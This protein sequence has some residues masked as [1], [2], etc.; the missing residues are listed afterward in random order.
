MIISNVTIQNM[1]YI[2]LYS[3]ESH[4]EKEKT[5]VIESYECFPYNRRIQNAPKLFGATF[6]GNAIKVKRTQQFDRKQLLQPKSQCLNVFNSI[7]N[8]Y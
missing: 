4:K 1:N 8:H 7:V 5:I 3:S 6:R 2:P